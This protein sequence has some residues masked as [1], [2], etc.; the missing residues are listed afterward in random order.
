M[1]AGPFVV[2]L[3]GG[4]STGKTTLAHALGQ[5][6]VTQGAEVRVVPEY[7]REFCDRHQ[8]TPSIGEQ[9]AIASE[10]SLRIA[11]AATGPV[12]VIADTTALMT[13]VYSDHLFN[14]ASLFADALQAHRH[15]AL[16]L[17]LAPDLPWRAD[18]YQRDGPQARDQVDQRLR[19]AL[20]KSGTPF[21][22]ICGSG[23]ER[24]HAALAAILARRAELTTRE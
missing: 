5:A 15:Y 18:G 16:N 11:A 24:V 3:L 14:D 23:A 10:Q 8:R 7:L 4:E 13:A 19:A 2:A 17:L 20:R 9:R 22:V 21:S 12:V 1:T 6:L